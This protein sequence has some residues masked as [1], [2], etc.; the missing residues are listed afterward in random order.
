METIHSI[1]ANNY[2]GKMSRHHEPNLMFLS[3]N[4]QFHL[5]VMNRLFY[6]GVKEE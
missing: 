1:I 2:D 5:Y 6:H 3:R 4:A